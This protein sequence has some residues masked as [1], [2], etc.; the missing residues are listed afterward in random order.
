MT[1]HHHDL[2]LEF[3]EHKE[4]IHS[5]K[6]TSERFRKLYDAY[7]A[8]DKQIYRSEERIDPLS[9]EAEEALKLQRVKLKDEL[10]GMINS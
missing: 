8:L 9:N 10:L 5:L 4:K 7:E 3:P 1:H 6:T 2:A